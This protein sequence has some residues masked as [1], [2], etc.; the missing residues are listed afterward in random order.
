VR[1]RLDAPATARF[2]TL[3]ASVRD[4]ADNAVTQTVV[5]AFGLK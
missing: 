5:R 2:V 1:F 3:R 4:A